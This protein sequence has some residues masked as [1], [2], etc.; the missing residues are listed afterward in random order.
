MTGS[1]M[2][3]TERD[4]AVLRDTVELAPVSRVQLQRLGYF[5]SRTR[6]NAVL[7]RLVRFGYLAVRRQPLVG[8]SRRLLYHLGRNGEELLG[9]EGNGRRLK[10][11]SDLFL[12]HH[13]RTT[14]VQIAF[15]VAED[16]ENVF[17][18]WLTD[19]QLRS[20]NLGV[21]PDGYVEYRY[22]TLPFAAFVE[23][24]LGTETLKRWEKKAAD[25]FRLAHSG[26][27]AAVC[28][29]RYFRV[30][31]VTVSTGRVDSLQKAISRVTPKIFWLTTI[32][33]LTDRGAFAPIWRRAQTGASQSLTQ[34][35]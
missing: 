14:D 3:L 18:R 10:Q 11:L 17:D 30:L 33:E 21:V 27:F 9:V 19:E 12:E 1:G 31:V 22:A 32:G 2:V 35:Q 7:A 23:V 34:S 25:Y 29:L 15:R 28:R 8:G 6:A 16:P 13:L 24:D 4:R 5:G 20:F 26:A